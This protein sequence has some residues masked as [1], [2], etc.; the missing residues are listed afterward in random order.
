MAIPTRSQCLTL[1]AQIHMPLHI[2]RHSLLVAEIAMLLGR[3]LNSNSAGL[4]L[5]VLQAGALLHDIGKMHGITTGAKHEEVG[6]R[7]LHDW[8]YLRL[9]PIVQDHVSLDSIRLYGPITESLI[10]NYADK[11][12]KHDEIVSL[13]DRFQDLMKRYARTEEHRVRLKEKLTLYLALERKIFEQLP[14]APND[15]ELMHLSLAEVP[16]SRWEDHESKETDGGVVVRRE[17]RRT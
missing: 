11:R 9:A 17:I 2:Q 15:A 16:E 5:K 13:R 7:M 3:R 1:L 10:V 14:I 12:V 8:G 6:S 4:N